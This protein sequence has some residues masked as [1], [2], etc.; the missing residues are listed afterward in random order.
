MG[1]KVNNIKDLREN[2][3]RISKPTQV[4]E[5]VGITEDDTVGVDTSKLGRELASKCGWNGSEIT[6]AYLEA[7]TD[8]NFHTERKKLAPILNKIFQSDFNADG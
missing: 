1:F 6:A 8:A 4:L 5:G 3:Q 2:F 7:L